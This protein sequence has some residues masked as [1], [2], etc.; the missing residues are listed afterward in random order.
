MSVSFLFGWS[1]MKNRTEWL[2]GDF[3]CST[4]L[5]TVLID[6][7]SLCACDLTLLQWWKHTFSISTLYCCVDSS[8]AGCQDWWLIDFTRVTNTESPE[9]VIAS[10][11]GSN[12]CNPFLPHTSS[13]SELS[14][15]EDG[16]LTRCKW[17]ERPLCL[18]SS[19]DSS[20]LMWVNVLI[21]TLSAGNVVN[22]E[23]L[24]EAR[25]EGQLDVMLSDRSRAHS[26]PVIGL[27]S[28]EQTDFTSTVTGTGN[29]LTT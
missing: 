10:L 27:L 13:S 1:W 2:H 29:T 20:R 15:V 26:G 12:A 3:I 17:S 28:R 8:W 14:S 19:R 25:C 5:F 22:F 9:Y 7:V 24:I 23:K 4:C 18:C 6:S 16:S 11:W 21:S